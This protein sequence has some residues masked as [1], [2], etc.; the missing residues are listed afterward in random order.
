VD[1]SAVEDVKYEAI[2][3]NLRTQQVM[4]QTSGQRKIFFMFSK[5][6]VELYAEYVISNTIAHSITNNKDI[7]I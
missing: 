3:A 5:L 2:S 4:Q 1:S 7:D 6:Q